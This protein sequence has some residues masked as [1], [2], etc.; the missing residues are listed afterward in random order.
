MTYRDR[1]K[2]ILKDK[3]FETHPEELEK[4]VEEIVAMG[5]EEV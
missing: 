2:S 3:C 4:V 5:R 1:L